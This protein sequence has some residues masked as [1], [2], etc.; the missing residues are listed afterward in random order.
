MFSR[1]V[2]KTP[3]RPFSAHSPLGQELGLWPWG[4]L[5][6]GFSRRG[7]GIGAKL[8]LEEQSAPSHKRSVRRNYF[9]RV[10]TPLRVILALMSCRV[11]M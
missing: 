7:L 10:W 11:K 4:H 9:T 6:S 5:G 3:G 8:I 1:L 2:R